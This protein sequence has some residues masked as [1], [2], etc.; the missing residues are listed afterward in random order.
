MRF[1]FYILFFILFF[2]LAI[3]ADVLMGRIIA[4]DRHR[5]EITLIAENCGQC[6]F[7][8]MNEPVENPNASKEPPPVPI[9]IS[10]DHIP[11][12]VKPHSFIRV[13]GEFSKEV[14]NRFLA[15]RIGGPGWRHNEPDST[16]VRSR[17]HKRCFLKE[18]HHPPG[19]PWPH[20]IPAHEQ[21]KP[22]E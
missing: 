8:E 1:S 5:G 20:D 13:W 15:N 11:F 9:V 22:V 12:F 3:R 21:N 17:L 18:K 16:G 14:D 2:P 19:P 10:A 6:R 4:I 7:N